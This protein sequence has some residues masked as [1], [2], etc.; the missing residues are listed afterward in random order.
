MH[1]RVTVEKVTIA[2]RIHTIL[3]GVKRPTFL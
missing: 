1:Q 3:S 2:A